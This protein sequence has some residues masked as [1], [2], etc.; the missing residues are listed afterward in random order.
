[1]AERDVLTMCDSFGIPR[2][3][4]QTARVDSAGRRRYTDAEWRLADGRVV[5]LE[6]DGGF[7]MHA[8]HWS[9]D[10]ERELRALGILGSSA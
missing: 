3:D 1:M 7:H 5:V 10:I 2:P 8:E 6:V 4:R 9:A